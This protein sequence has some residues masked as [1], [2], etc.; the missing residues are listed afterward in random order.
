MMGVVAIAAGA[1]VIGFNPNRWD[2]VILILPRGHGIHLK[3][4]VGATFV[5]LGTA[6]LWR[7]PRRR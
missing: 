2:V 6:T 5:A 4:V 7:L 1:V 3:D